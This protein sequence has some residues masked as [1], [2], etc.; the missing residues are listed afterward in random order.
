MYIIIYKE[1]K[2]NGEGKN[3]GIQFERD[4][5][6]YPNAYRLRRQGPPLSLKWNLS[7]LD[8]PLI[9]REKDRN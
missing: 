9:T 5:Q 8:F 1:D 6:R 2:K 4:L 3:V 7:K